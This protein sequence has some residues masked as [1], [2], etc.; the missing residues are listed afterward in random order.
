MITPMHV[1]KGMTN[2]IGLPGDLEFN[3]CIID[4]QLNI[5]NKYTTCKFTWHIEN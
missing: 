4:Y 3:L 2:V 1:P 5:T